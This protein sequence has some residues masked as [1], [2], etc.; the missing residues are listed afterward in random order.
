VTFV[1]FDTLIVINIYISFNIVLV[2]ALGHL[3]HKEDLEE[4]HRLLL[5]SRTIVYPSQLRPEISPFVSV[6]FNAVKQR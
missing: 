6:G 5:S 3:L 4:N 1:I 2:N